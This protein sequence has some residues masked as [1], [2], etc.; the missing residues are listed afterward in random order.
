MMAV[1]GV[2]LTSESIFSSSTKSANGGWEV[3]IAF[4]SSCT[5][6]CFRSRNVVPVSW[7]DSL[8][9]LEGAGVLGKLPSM[10]FLRPHGRGSNIH[11]S[12]VTSRPTHPVSARKRLGLGTPVARRLGAGFKAN[13]ILVVSEGSQPY[14]LLRKVSLFEERCVALA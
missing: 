12:D 9:L 10:G 8:S 6:L 1:F 5:T 2:A 3:M 14:A 4:D 7:S 13:G 11:R